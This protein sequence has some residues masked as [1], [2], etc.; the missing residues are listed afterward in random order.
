MPLRFFPAKIYFT[1]KAICHIPLLLAFHS[2][3]AKRF[4]KQSNIDLTSD[5]SCVVSYLIVS[6]SYTPSPQHP[7]NRRNHFFSHNKMG[8]K[9]F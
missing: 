3:K 5:I 4:K 2:L 7:D 9:G 6:L 1:E 8:K